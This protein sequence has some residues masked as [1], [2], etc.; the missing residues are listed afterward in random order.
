MLTRIPPFFTHGHGSLA[1]RVLVLLLALGMLVACGPDGGR[2][3]AATVDEHAAHVASDDTAPAATADAPAFA[4]SLYDLGA[5]WQDQTGADVA[6]DAL[7]GQV[8]VVAMVYASCSHTCP[9]I[10]ADLKRLE[11]VL[12]A[13]AADVG[14]VLVTLDPARDTPER[15]AD[16]ARSSRLDAPRWTLL[17]GSDD[18]VLEL[19]AALGVRYRAGA[20]GEI[21]HSNVYFVLDQDGAVV[22]RQAGVGGDPAA[23]R[24]AIERLLD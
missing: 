8:R 21:A 4:G 6:F 14:F 19:S 13:R 22:H 2:A 23:A 12:G 7:G 16:F 5:R 24:H 3:Q 1:L 11:G 20:G 17:T 15:L 9:L 18:A 10:V